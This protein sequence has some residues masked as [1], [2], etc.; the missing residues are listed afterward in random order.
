MAWVEKDH[1]DHPVPT[2]CCVQGHHPAA[3]AAQRHIPPGLECLQGWG[4][5]RIPAQP[6]PVP[7][8]PH[9][10]RLLPYIQPKSPLFQFEAI[11]PRPFTTDPA[12]EAVPSFT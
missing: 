12:K 4:V 8:C 7:H 6:V 5:H 10:K 9:C 1:S 11:S 3:Q 2:A